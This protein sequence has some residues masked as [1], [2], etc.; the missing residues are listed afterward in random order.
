M[1]LANCKNE[2]HPHYVCAR[3]KALAHDKTMSTLKENKFCINCLKP[4]HFVKQCKSL[5]HCRKCQKLHHTLFHVETEQGSHTSPVS[6]TPVSTNTTPKSVSSHTAA[7]LSSNTLLM[8]CRVLVDAPDGSTV[9]AGALLD[10]ASSASFVSERLAQTLCLPRSH[11]STKVSGIAGLSHGSPL[12]KR[13]RV[14]YTVSSQEEGS[15]SHHCATS[16]M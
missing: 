1:T 5:H 6:S 4:G 12:R 16:N 9:E 8:T 11:Q 13:Q 14:F 7:G 10:S 2:K 3:F 15:R